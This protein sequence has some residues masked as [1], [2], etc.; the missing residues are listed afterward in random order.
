MK[1]IKTIL[2]TLTGV[3]ALAAPMIAISCNNG[4]KKEAEKPVPE[5]TDVKNPAPE[6]STPEPSDGKKPSQGG[7]TNPEDVKPTP[8]PVDG[9]QPAPEKTPQADPAVKTPAQLVEEETKKVQ[10]NLPKAFMENV[11]ASKAKVN[12]SALTTSKLNLVGYDTEKYD[13]TVLSIAAD[14]PAGT[15]TV[16]FELKLKT[17]NKVKAEKSVVIQGF[18]SV[19]QEDVDALKPLTIGEITLT[20]NQKDIEAAFKLISEQNGQ[21][22]L[23][24]Y[25]SESILNVKDP[26]ERNKYVNLTEGHI[27]IRDL[28]LQLA[29]ANKIAFRNKKNYLTPSGFLDIVKFDQEKRE[30]TIQYRVVKDIDHIYTFSNPYEL[31]IKFAKPE[32]TPVTTPAE[33]GEKPVE[34]GTNNSTG[35]TETGKDTTSGTEETPSASPAA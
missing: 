13:A 26:S 1:K 35:S 20:T 15:L 31:T 18:H 5:K 23:S 11:D 28:K 6:T 9:E 19:P 16:K 3:T 7:A 30:L 34:A 4:T 29:S 25:F 17:D 12:A 22:Q 24:Y 27:Y 10:V 33:G 21:K 32:A 8:K 14:N 2:L